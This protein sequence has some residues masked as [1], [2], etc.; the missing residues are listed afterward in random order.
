MKTGFWSLLLVVAFTLMASLAGISQA[1]ES[2]KECID[3]C[4]EGT[5]D[6]FAACETRFPKGSENA[7]VIK[8]CKKM[9]KVSEAECIK[10]CK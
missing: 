5:K 9:C 1:G 7:G 6:C 8:Q 4:K 10:E 2:R 3:E